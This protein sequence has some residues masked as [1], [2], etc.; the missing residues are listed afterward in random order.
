MI[1]VVSRVVECAIACVA[2]CC[3]TAGSDRLGRQDKKPHIVARTVGCFACAFWSF[4]HIAHHERDVRLLD[5]SSDF[6]AD[7][8]SRPRMP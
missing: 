2:G 8:T 6:S 4:S 7:R 1:I 3:G 5:L